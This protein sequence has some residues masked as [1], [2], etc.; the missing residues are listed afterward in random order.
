[1]LDVR[2][3][4]IGKIIPMRSPLRSSMVVG[5]VRTMKTEERKI[6]CRAQGHPWRG[7]SSCSSSLGSDRLSYFFHI[8]T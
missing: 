1:M 8:F 2:V 6:Q 5:A 3:S 4:R 7:P